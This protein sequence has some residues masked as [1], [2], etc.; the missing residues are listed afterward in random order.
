PLYGS[1]AMRAS[2]L[3]S[4]AAYRRLLVL[5]TEHSLRLGRTEDRRRAEAL[6]LKEMGNAGDVVTFGERGSAGEPPAY[7]SRGRPTP[8]PDAREIAF[9][10]NVAAR[11]RTMDML[12]PHRVAKAYRAEA[13][14]HPQL[15]P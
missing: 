12:D 4:E 3:G 5:A 8:A 2:E 15:T 1:A 14:M 13:A 7:G 10:E 9:S 11:L 6:L